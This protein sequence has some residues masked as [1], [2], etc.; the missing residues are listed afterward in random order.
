MR[1]S[2]RDGVASLLA[3]LGAVVMFAKLQSYSWWLIGSWKGAL[4]VLAV[5]GGAI[6]LTNVVELVR[7]ASLPSMGE[8]GLWVATA[9]VVIASLFS[10]TTKAEFVSSGVMIGLAWLSQLTDHSWTTAHTNKHGYISAH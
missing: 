6:L 5:V 9:T 8:V 2:W 7:A 1:L 4:G 10:T 3:L